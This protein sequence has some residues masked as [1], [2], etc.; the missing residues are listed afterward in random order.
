MQETNK[1]DLHH[2]EYFL[3][4]ADTRSTKVFVSKQGEKIRAT[5]DPLISKCDIMSCADSK[6]CKIY[7]PGS[8]VPWAYHALDKA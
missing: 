2:V 1:Q 7:V 8:Y 4:C 5:V 6:A 3:E